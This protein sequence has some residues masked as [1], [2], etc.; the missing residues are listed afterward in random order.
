M[1][2]SVTTELDPD[3]DAYRMTEAARRLSVSRSLLYRLVGEGKLRTVKV[4]GVT[5]VPR[6]EVERL[7][8]DG[9]A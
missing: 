9:V 8:R 5:L 2:V 6:D 3:R 1:L 4:G 7:V